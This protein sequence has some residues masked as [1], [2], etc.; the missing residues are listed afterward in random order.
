V[1]ELLEPYWGFRQ[2]LGPSAL[3]QLLRGRS[4]RP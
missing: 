2:C 1:A 4:K 3:N